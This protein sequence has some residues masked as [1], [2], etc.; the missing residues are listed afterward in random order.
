MTATGLDESLRDQNVK[1]FRNACAARGQ[2]GGQKFMRKRPLIAG[3]AVVRHQKQRK[4]L[5]NVRT[6]I[7]GRTDDFRRLCSLTALPFVAG[8]SATGLSVTDA[9]RPSRCR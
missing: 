1:R 5:W 2:H 9:W 3:R 6:S 8:G 4:T 7:H